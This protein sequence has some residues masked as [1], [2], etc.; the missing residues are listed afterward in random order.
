MTKYNR[1]GQELK[2]L[3]KK[4]EKAHKDMQKEFVIIPEHEGS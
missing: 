4:N 2:K 3:R 1:C